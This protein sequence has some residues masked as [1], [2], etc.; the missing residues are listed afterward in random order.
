MAGEKSGLTDT[1]FAKVLNSV[2][3]RGE[4][5]NEAPSSVNGLGEAAKRETKQD[6]IKQ[7]VSEF[8]GSG[9]KYEL[10]SGDIVILANFDSK[11]LQGSKSKSIRATIFVNNEKTDLSLSAFRDLMMGSK[12][13]NAI[14]VN[15]VETRRVLETF[16]NSQQRMRELLMEIDS[17]KNNS[18]LEKIKDKLGLLNGKFDM[19]EMEDN[20]RK[21]NIDLDKIKE[22]VKELAIWN[23][24]IA[25]FL[26]KNKPAENNDSAAEIEKLK[27]K[28]GELKKATSDLRSTLFHGF[29][30]SLKAKELIERHD[31]LIGLVV[32]E[33]SAIKNKSET[34]YL[35]DQINDLERWNG[36]ADEFLA[37]CNE[38]DQ[39]AKFLIKEYTDKFEE[40]KL[41]SEELLGKVEELRIA[42][43]GGEEPLD[44]IYEYEPLRKRDDD[45]LNGDHNEYAIQEFIRQVNDLEL[46]KTKVENLLSKVAGFHENNDEKKGAESADVI[47][48]RLVA[49][50]GET[51]TQYKNEL[52]EIITVL[53]FIPAKDAEQDEEKVKVG[54]YHG[55]DKRLVSLIEFKSLLNNAERITNKKIEPKKKGDPFTEKSN[56]AKKDFISLKAILLEK[57][58]TKNLSTDLSGELLGEA[59]E[60][61]RAIN[62]L[63]K[64]GYINRLTMLEKIE[65]EIE[66]FL[67]RAG[68]AD[69]KV[70]KNGLRDDPDEYIELFRQAIGPNGEQLIE[71]DAAKLVLHKVKNWS[72]LNVG[73]S[74]LSDDDIKKRARDL[75][76]WKEFYVHGMGRGSDLKQRTDLDGNGALEMFKRAGIPIDSEL[77]M[78]SGKDNKNR[79]VFYLPKGE[80]KKGGV[81]LDSGNKDGLVIT[82]EADGKISVI[83]D[84][85]GNASGRGASAT[86]VAW[87]ILRSYGLLEDSLEI[88]KFIY[89][90]NQIDNFNYPNAEEYFK[91]ENYFDHSWD[92]MLGIQGMLKPENLLAFFRDGHNSIDEISKLGLSND[93]L[94]EYGII[95]SG[96]NMSKDD[97]ENIQS[98]YGIKKEKGRWKISSAKEKELNKNNISYNRKENRLVWASLDIREKQKKSVDSSRSELERMEKEGFIIDSSFG[99]IAVDVGGKIYDKT[100]ASKAFGCSIYLNFTPGESGFF[101]SSLDGEPLVLDGVNFAEKFG[102][103]R[104]VRETMWLDAGNEAKDAFDLQVVLDGMCGGKFQATGE[105]VKYLK[106]AGVAGGDINPNKKEPREQFSDL[107]N[108]LG[109]KLDTNNFSINLEGDLLHEHQQLT[110]TLERLLQM[111]GDDHA[112]RLVALQGIEKAVNEFI[113]KVREAELAQKE[114]QRQEEEL[115]QKRSAGEKDNGVSPEHLYENER[116]SMENMRAENWVAK[117]WSEKEQDEN[118]ESVELSFRLD[119]ARRAYVI[120]SNQVKEKSSLMK[121]IFGFGSGPK[122]GEFN[123]ELELAKSD[124]EEALKNYKNFLTGN[125][126]NEGEAEVYD[127]ESGSLRESTDDEKVEMT[128]GDAWI[129]AKYLKHGEFLKIESTRAEIMVENRSWPEIAKRK[130]LKIIEDYKQLPM[131][132]KLIIAAAL[133]ATGL[134]TGAW[135][136]AA[137]GTAVMGARKLFSISVSSLGYASVFEALAAKGINKE[138]TEETDNLVAEV[139][140]NVERAEFDVEEFSRLLDES[141]EGVDNEVN[142]RDLKKKW[143]GYTAVAAGVATSML[144]S[145]AGKVGSHLIGDAVKYWSGFLGHHEPAIPV[146]YTG[147][148]HINTG[149]GAHHE[150]SAGAKAVVA[151]KAH[152]TGVVHPSG[153]KSF[154]EAVNAVKAEHNAIVNEDLPNVAV[155]EHGSKAGEV[156]TGANVGADDVV[157][158]VAKKSAEQ[159]NEMAKDHVLEIKPGS[160]IEATIRDHYRAHPEVLKAYQD[161]VGK[162]LTPGQ[163]AHRMWL[164]FGDK[165]DLV[166]AGA[167]IHLPADAQDILRITDDANMGQ[168]HHDVAS[169]ATE[170]VTTVS[171]ADVVQPVTEVAHVDASPVE[172]PIVESVNTPAE[173]PEFKI[174]STFA[175]GLLKIDQDISV[176]NGD[177]SRFDSAITEAYY[178]IDT[179]SHLSAEEIMKLKVDDIRPYNVLDITKT[180]E[181]MDSEKTYL[182][183]LIEQRNLLGEK[184]KNLTA[185]RNFMN[186]MNI[187]KYIGNGSMLNWNAVQGQS[188]EQLLADKKEVTV[189]KFFEYLTKADGARM[190]KLREIMKPKAD[191]TVGVWVTRFVKSASTLGI[192][193]I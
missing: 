191:E 34:D 125:M 25:E 64:V 32:D 73:N 162:K 110:E 62:M 140:P 169:H 124:Y 65:K 95:Q 15:S 120:K 136:G 105:L 102:I 121:R 23:D 142:A 70:E 174:E 66:E 42:R 150:V 137:A 127:K 48:E 19:N 41:S 51:G 40:L 166:H 146:G 31:V 75:E 54:I 101:M 13:I 74:D 21:G 108:E 53:K 79:N 184:L 118:A 68:L 106:G 119:E 81:T 63:P 46:W 84:H 181:A 145:Y 59:Q 138:A 80:Y 190:D 104:V 57:L 114:K 60:F 18:E 37:E 131:K 164:E 99:K 56:N 33:T 116:P 170:H 185:G 14:E 109:Q 98:L 47:I 175:E 7:L 49:E 28:L 123:N 103:G 20:I 89:F 171:H 179:S 11:K 96:V 85:H 82:K 187:R 76:I 72:E 10:P 160:S 26:Q 144:G 88:G 134:A 176:I 168:L 192:K 155:A 182:K 132:K 100:G 43:V 12:R 39:Y 172:A 167:K 52:G 113:N 17:V 112:E 180:A 163:I 157:A 4:S 67:K 58:N 154:D 16:K 1:P 44:L 87:N 71:R 77:R 178:Q 90:V 30:I 135:A 93:K 24:E 156:L 83:A 141:I 148:N 61:T 173:V 38:H 153:A 189:N 50:F 3:G 133:G 122:L 27:L 29:R 188:M 107:A 139:A 159:V 111:R 126:I 151:E 69:D 2:N 78:A 36:E 97:L 22:C 183:Y 115:K 91:K 129:I 9:T 143:R 94:V 117:G 55:N 165:R 8:G 152:E 186:V 45:A 193:N 158:E 35:N 92:T 161:S 177:I 5:T 149:E 128:K 130:Y 6:P 86:E 147:E